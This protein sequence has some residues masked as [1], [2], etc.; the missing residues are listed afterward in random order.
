MSDSEES[1]RDI[2]DEQD[3][4]TPNFIEQLKGDNPKIFGIDYYSVIYASAGFLA[5]VMFY[6]Y[7]ITE[8]KEIQRMVL[9]QGALALG[10]LF[11]SMYYRQRIE[12]RK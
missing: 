4:L 6:L 8:D 3:D 12:A 1:P 2:E 7:L 11:T 5:V 9:I 10:L